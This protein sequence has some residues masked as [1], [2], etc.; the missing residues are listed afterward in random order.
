MHKL[1]IGLAT[2]GDDTTLHALMVRLDRTTGK[3]PTG[4]AVIA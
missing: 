3:L 1:M 2:A 4:L